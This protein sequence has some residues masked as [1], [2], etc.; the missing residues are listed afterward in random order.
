MLP[1]FLVSIIVKYNSMVSTLTLFVHVKT[2]V[3]IDKQQ[4]DSLMLLL[5][6]L[7]Q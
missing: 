5:L 3:S 2:A 4:Y 7:V 1:N 6:L